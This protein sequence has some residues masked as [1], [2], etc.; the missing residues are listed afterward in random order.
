[1]VKRRKERLRGMFALMRGNFLV[2]TLCTSC[3]LPLTHIFSP[4]ESVYLRALGASSLIIGTY[5]AVSHL[6]GQLT[7]VPGG[8]L[9][10]KYGRRKII[11]IGNYLAAFIRLFVAF[12]T[13]WYSYFAARLALSVASFWAIAENV[14]LIDSMNVENR[15][16]SFSIFWF[17]TQAAGLASPYIGGWLLENRQ[18]EGL[19]LV[20][21][22]IAAADAI[23]ASVYTRFLKETLRPVK[24][25]KRFSILSILNPLAE[26]F[27]TLKWVPR[28]LLG[29][30]ALSIINGFSWAMI[31]PF[32]TL[33][34]FDVILLSPTAWGLIHTIEIGVILILRIPGGWVTDRYSK[35]KLILISSVANLGFFIAFI[36]SRSFLQVL[37]AIIAKRTI[38]TLT[39]PAWPALQADLTPREHRGKVS[40]LL[41]VLGAPFGFAGAIVGGY[42]YGLLPV[43]LFWAFIP[44]NILAFL[45]TFLFVHE[46]KK[47][48]E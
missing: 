40:S 44:F 9:C 29:F 27:K 16:M 15:G 10:D 35:R 31:S 20:L 14:I 2:V 26:T 38:L 25:E 41:T 1:M 4:Y 43:L 42:L 48:A 32:I 23:K 28:S 30:C 6:I 13:D 45:V 11:V 18:A 12:S 17:V 21:F 39:D 5:S 33:Y 34:A 46:P 47:P 24:E 3:F 19:R 22:L 7:S 36:F 8:Y 37:L